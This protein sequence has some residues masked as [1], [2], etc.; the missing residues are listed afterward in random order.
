MVDPGLLRVRPRCQTAIMSSPT[1]VGPG[2]GRARRVPYRQP[3]R[4]TQSN[5]A[6]LSLPADVVDRVT[7]AVTDSAGT[8]I[9]GLQAQPGGAAI[10]QAAGD[11][12]IHASRLTTGLAAI[13]LVVGLLA[14][15]R[16]PRS[17]D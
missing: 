7:A 10:A 12:M 4:T 13:A 2:S 6:A 9:A 5:L 14:T 8:A 3:R 1:R 16:L 15:F 11:A 17:A